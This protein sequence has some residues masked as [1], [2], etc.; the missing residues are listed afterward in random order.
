MGID[1]LG[2]ASP[3]LLRIKKVIRTVS[4]RQAE[5]LLRR[6]LLMRTAGAVRALL[7]EALEQA[8][9]DMLM[10]QRSF[11]LVHP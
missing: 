8:G 5:E 1:V 4:R 3:R 2:M 11:D 9:L 7:N 6:A 10:A